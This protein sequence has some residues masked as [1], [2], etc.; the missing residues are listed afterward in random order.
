MS[1][2]KSTAAPLISRGLPAVVGGVVVSAWPGVT[3]ATFAVC[4][5]IAA[6]I[7]IMRA[8]SNDRIGP[9]AR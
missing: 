4:A 8:F 5:L 3:T 6:G 1:R 2:A 9:V 7:T